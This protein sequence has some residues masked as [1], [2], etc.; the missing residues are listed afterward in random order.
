M[1]SITIGDNEIVVSAMH[2][3]IESIFVVSVDDPDD[4]LLQLIQENAGRLGREFL[5]EF[6]PNWKTNGVN[7]FQFLD[8]FSDC[9]PPIPFVG[10]GDICWL[11]PDYGFGDN[12]NV[13]DP[14]VKYQ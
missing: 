6:F 8:T 7:V 1:Q 4:D 12:I 2:N 13:I 14:E 3:D 10:I 11:S 9:E 5:D